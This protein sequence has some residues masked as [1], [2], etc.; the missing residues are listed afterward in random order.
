MGR[1]KRKLEKVS[2]QP[3]DPF[4]FNEMYKVDDDAHDKVD[5]KLR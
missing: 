2:Y 1:V 5:T 3:E 4:H